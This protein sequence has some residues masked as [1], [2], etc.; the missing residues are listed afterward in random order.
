MRV[1]A[2][3]VFQFLKQIPELGLKQI[4]SP[5]LVFIREEDCLCLDPFDLFLDSVYFC[6]KRLNL[7]NLLGAL[8]IRDFV[9][10]DVVQELFQELYAVL[11]ANEEL[12]SARIADE[13]RLA[14]LVRAFL[15]SR[16]AQ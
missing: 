8:P 9:L 16:C 14:I 2:C 12:N 4:A 5:D 7:V 13:V 10:G 3:H 1:L 15:K 6:E 11:P